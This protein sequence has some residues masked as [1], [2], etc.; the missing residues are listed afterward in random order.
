[1]WVCMCFDVREVS[2]SCK[3]VVTVLTVS[4]WAVIKECSNGKGQTD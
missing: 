3:E 4:K 1:M 2:A